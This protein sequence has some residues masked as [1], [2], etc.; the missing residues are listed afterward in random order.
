MPSC[1]SFVTFAKSAV[2]SLEG[3]QKGVQEGFVYCQK[4]KWAFEDLHRNLEYNPN[5]FNIFYYY[6]IRGIRKFILKQLFKDICD[7]VQYLF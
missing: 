1:G 7:K 5:R 2:N 6:Y 4:V 3:I